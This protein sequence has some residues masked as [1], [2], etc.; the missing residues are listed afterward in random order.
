[1]T[2][3]S[4]GLLRLRW[5]LAAKLA[6]GLVLGSVL[7]FFVFGYAHQRIEQRHLE[8][9][10]RLSAE[11]ISDII[12]S[13]AWQHM[14]A[15]DR[16]G[17]YELIRNVG[18]EPGIL[19]L[20]LMNENGLI[21]HSTTDAEIG[22]IVDRRA[23]ACYAC[24]SEAAPR[25]A[26]SGK[27]RTR[28]FRNEKGTRTL[29]AILPIQNA[30]DC[31]NAACHAHPE[32]RRVL[33]V[34]DVHLS[35]DSVDAQLAEYRSQMALYMV[36]GAAFLCVF[37][38]L[39]VWRV[40]HRPL[41]ELTAGTRKVA[42]GSLD[43]RIAV[44]SSDELGV[45]A[46]SFNRMTE[47]LARAYAELKEW[48]RTLERRVD[49]KT[50]ALERAHASLLRSEKMAS[51]GRLAATVA[52]EVNNPLFGMLT[53]A[54]LIRKDIGKLTM[55]DKLRSRFD[56]HLG[57]I[58]RESIRCGDLMKS[59]LQFSRQ[60][61]IQPGNCQVNTIVERACALVHHQMELAEVDLKLQ[62]DPTLGEII[63][64]AGQVQ[65][66]LVALLVNANEAIGRKGTI[67]VATRPHNGGAAISIRDTGPG[68]PEE[69]QHQIFEPFFTTKENH[70]RTGLG[71]AVAKDI[72]ER[73]GGVLRLNSAPGQG[74]EFI[75]ELPH[76][77]ATLKPETVCQKEP[78]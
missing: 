78:S 68:I 75:V 5:G 38:V 43:Y 34:I 33:G 73:H 29:A 45:L 28:I 25:V 55:E 10:V 76:A 41:R 39:F 31:S 53:Y 14:M 63:A 17:L 4:P 57:V 65:Q 3:R 56:E 51:L 70:H 74:A 58:E 61:P 22:T 49:E 52:H 1:M 7:F 44:H 9:L 2:E 50:Y 16:P 11:R 62:L 69:I 77:P 48:A 36:G 18:K 67:T 59:L 32:S 71:L 60:A 37:A 12:R 27:E 47:K 15:N 35:L 8:G 23:E 54:R 40:L 19:R 42:Q 24:H 72:V 21:R 66:I 64:D 13:A 26:L 20:R 6:A 46:E 30:P